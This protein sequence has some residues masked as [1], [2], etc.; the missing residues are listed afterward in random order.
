MINIHICSWGLKKNF[1]VNLNFAI[2][3]NLITINFSKLLFSCLICGICCWKDIRRVWD[4][5]YTLLNCM[6]KRSPKDG[7]YHECTIVSHLKS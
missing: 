2:S 4:I 3:R 1:V 5:L 7:Y 6:N